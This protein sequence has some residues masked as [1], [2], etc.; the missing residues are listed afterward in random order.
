MIGSFLLILGPA[1]QHSAA[2]CAVHKSFFSF[3]NLRITESIDKL[4]NGLL[5]FLGFSHC[6]GR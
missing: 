6:I 5:D 3:F 4:V 2:Q 1:V